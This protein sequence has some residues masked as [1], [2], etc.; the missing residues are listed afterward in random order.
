MRHFGDDDS[1]LSGADI[2]KAMRDH[3]RRPGVSVGALDA[4]VWLAALG[5]ALALLWW[6]VQ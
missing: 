4:V 2:S 6:A 1:E 3:V 5:T